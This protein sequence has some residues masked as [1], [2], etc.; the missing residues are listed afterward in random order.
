MDFEELLKSIK[1]SLVEEFGDQWEGLKGAVK[2]DIDQ[3]LEKSRT[4]LKRWTLLLA[5]GDLTIDDFEWLVR[6]QKDLMVLKS[7]Q[8]AGLH[9]ISLGHFRNK[10]IRRI[11]DIIGVAVLKWF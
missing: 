2:K 11:V 1:A 6:S 5:N 10:V 9:K 3:F 8:S 7:L 4:K